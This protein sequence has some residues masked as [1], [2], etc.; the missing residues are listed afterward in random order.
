MVDEKK[1]SEAITKVKKASQKRNFSQ[2]VDLIINLKDI[3]ISKSGE[4]VEEHVV[5]PHGSSKPAKICAFVGGELKADA[6]KLCDTVILDT[7]FDQW[8]DQ[9]K[10]KK[11]A[12]NC[13]F[14]IAQANVMPEVAKR[15]GKYLAPRAKMP[16]PKAGQV[17]PP[18]A[19]LKPLV[20]KLRN[21]VLVQTK[22][23]PVIQCSIGNEKMKED[24]LAEN[25]TTILNVLEHK[26]PHGKAN[27]QTIIIKT[28]MGKPVKI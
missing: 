2:S 4:K 25:I 12:R 19:N 3:D 28:T 27:I 14:F 26:L 16:N 15:F 1:I 7:K 23:V 24:E 18:K 9:R 21:T 17:V 13:D 6:E 20:E 10:F 11:L 5:L 22:K 8:K